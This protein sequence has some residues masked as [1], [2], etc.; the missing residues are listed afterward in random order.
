MMISFEKYKTAEEATTAAPATNLEEAKADYCSLRNVERA[1]VEH[2]KACQAELVE[3]K[4]Q[5]NQAFEVVRTLTN[6]K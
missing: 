5:L 3:T 1:L 2:I 6:S 4:R